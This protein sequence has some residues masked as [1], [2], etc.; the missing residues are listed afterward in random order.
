MALFHIDMK[1]SATSSEKSGFLINRW[2]NISKITNRK[3]KSDLRPER[4]DFYRGQVL[5]RGVETQAHFYSI[6]LDIFIDV[7]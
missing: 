6:H 2:R 3:P 5:S 4:Q 1:Y 7:C